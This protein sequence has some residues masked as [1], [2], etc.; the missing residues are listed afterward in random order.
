MQPDIKQQKCHT[1]FGKDVGCFV[2]FNHTQGK[3]TDQHPSN[4]ISDDNTDTDGACSDARH[5][6]GSEKCDSW[7]E[8]LGDRHARSINDML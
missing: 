3:R 8:R 2:L 4:E 6:T 1:Q 7:L 5:Q